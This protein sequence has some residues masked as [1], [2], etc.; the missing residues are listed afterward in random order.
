MIGRKNAARTASTPSIA[1]ESKIRKPLSRAIVSDNDQLKKKTVTPWRR[2]RRVLLLQCGALLIFLV[3]MALTSFGYHRRHRNKLTTLQRREWMQFVRKKKI[4][5]RVSK[6]P[7][8]METMLATD[9]VVAKQWE[10]H[11]KERPQV[12][13]LFQE[14]GIHPIWNPDPESHWDQ[15][16]DNLGTGAEAV[17]D[18][19]HNGVM[20]PIVGEDTAHY[21]AD[22]VHKG[23]DS[24]G[25]LTEDLQTVYDTVNS[26][27]NTTMGATIDTAIEWMGN[28]T[29]WYNWTESFSQA[30]STLSSLWNYTMELLEE[31][32][33]SEETEEST[34]HGEDEVG[35]KREKGETASE[36]SRTPGNARDDE[37]QKPMTAEDRAAVVAKLREKELKTPMT[38]EDRAALVAKLRE[39]ELKPKRL[40][41]LGSL[42]FIKYAF[43]TTGDPNDPKEVLRFETF[44]LG[45]LNTYLDD[46]VLFYVVNFRAVQKVQ[47]LCELK[48]N[49]VTCKRLI[50]VPVRCPP[51]DYG[52]ST[53]CHQDKGLSQITKNYPDYDWYI[54]HEDDLYFRTTFLKLFLRGLPNP[55]NE[56]LLL[57]ASPFQP[58]GQTTYPG[59]GRVESNCSSAPNHVYPWGRPAIIYSNAAMKSLLPSY[60]K[61]AITRECDA[62]RVTADAGSPIVHWM[63]QLPIVQLPRIASR[64]WTNLKTRLLGNQS[65]YFQ[66]SIAFRA[67]ARYNFTQ[68]DKDVQAASIEAKA[69]SISSLLFPLPPYSYKIH[70]PTG[71]TETRI[72]K[73][74]G[75]VQNWTRW[76][77][78]APFDCIPKDNMTF[79]ND[80]LAQQKSR[81]PEISREL[82]L[83]ENQTTKVKEVPKALKQEPKAL[84]QEPKALKQEPKALKQEDNDEKELSESTTSKSEIKTTEQ[85]ANKQPV[86]ADSVNT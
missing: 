47:Q 42:A 49:N 37:A 19:L 21:V 14:E 79:S 70:R 46:T 10:T 35:P 84:K 40:Q 67:E 56:S 58:H 41:T 43:I 54:Y 64:S 77:T 29:D 23:L 53:C 38:A 55:R 50:V 51:R 4:K 83:V 26:L 15:A 16:A 69:K 32:D 62:F 24:I 12:G 2:R 72:F 75:A 13:R 74:Y 18:W 3:F 66:H 20:E 65:E 7:K 9:P 17:V 11:L 39:K 27:L 59:K 6:F 8:D 45:A 48:R 60:S 36:K 68:I 30:S 73:K 80:V 52:V 28:S 22:T 78:F 25:D 31:P 82:S 61:L 81:R 76:H 57:S 33:D 1:D 34:H 85:D 86:Q 44:V 5:S 63:H 71:F